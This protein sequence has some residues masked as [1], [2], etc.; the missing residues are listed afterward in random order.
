MPRQLSRRAVATTGIIAVLWWVA[1]II[2]GLLDSHRVGSEWGWTSYTPIAAS[3]A[4]D[5]IGWVLW[6][7]ATVTIGAGVILL[8]MLVRTR[9]QI[10]SWVVPV[11]LLVVAGL[12]SIQA[13]NSTLIERIYSGPGSPDEAVLIDVEDTITGPQEYNPPLALAVMLTSTA[14]VL[15]ITA[16]TAPRNGPTADSRDADEPPVI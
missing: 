13:Y 7:G 5:L 11:G 14:I 3:E 6:T 16:W 15:A 9:R 4:N 1:A 12:T 10:G 2:W 8:V